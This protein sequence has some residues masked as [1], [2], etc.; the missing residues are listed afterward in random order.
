MSWYRQARQR[1]QGPGCLR[2]NPRMKYRSGN[3]RHRFRS[4]ARLRSENTDVISFGVSSKHALSEYSKYWS[5]IHKPLSN[6]SLTLTEVLGFAGHDCVWATSSAFTKYNRRTAGDTRPSIH[7]KPAFLLYRALD[8]S[9]QAHISNFTYNKMRVNKYVFLV[10]LWDT[11]SETKNRI[12]PA[13]LMFG[14]TNRLYEISYR[15]VG[16]GYYLRAGKHVCEKEPL[17]KSPNGQT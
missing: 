7:A 16:K 10:L 8:L 1:R 9:S 13:V 11:D 6:D 4:G 12:L 14:D 5:S 17:R 3:T 15:R 2:A